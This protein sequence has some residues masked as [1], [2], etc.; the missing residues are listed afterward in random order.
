MHKQQLVVAILAGIAGVVH[1]ASALNLNPN[2]LGQVLIYPYYT[3]NAGQQTLLSVV[4]T[5]NVGKVV[6]VRFLEGYNGR[7][8]LDFNLFLSRNDVW[9]ATL[10]SV[11]DLPG[12]SGGDNSFAG[13]FTT[14]NSCTDP[15]LTGSG[16]FINPATG[17][18]QA[19]QRFVND[20]YTG[21]NADTG[22]TSDA[23]TREGHFELILESDVLIGSVLDNAITHVQPLGMPADCRAGRLESAPGYAPPTLD[24]V[25]GVPTSGVDYAVDGG[26]LGSASIIEVAEGAFYAYN[27]DAL[28]GFSDYDLHGPLNSASPSLVPV[29]TLI[30]CNIGGCPPTLATAN[31]FANGKA[32]AATFVYG[33][34][35]QENRLIDAVSAVFAADNVHNEYV[36]AADGSVGTDWVLT[37][38][39]KRFYVDAQPGGAIAA[40]ITTAT[41]ATAFAPFEELFGQVT[42]GRSCVLVGSGSQVYNREE[43]SAGITTCLVEMESCPPIPAQICLETNVIRFQLGSV[44]GSILPTPNFA[45]L[46]SSGWFSL[47]LATNGSAHSNSGIDGNGHALYPA[48]NGDIFHGLPVTGFAAI[49]YINGSVP[50]SGGGSALANYTAGYHHREKSNC[51]NATGA[52]S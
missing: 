28:D 13:I 10:F 22:P 4:N 32:L 36:T 39:T 23:R 21:A 2:G 31:V 11:G 30:G 1:H 45:P 6:N 5:T 47:D 48:S 8:V 17:A 24:P 19:Y 52:C 35:S 16:T 41:V 37:F 25:T 27:A 40:S 29:D 14:D 51:T 3:V 7:D 18:A 20:N 26:L 34:F 15:A 9:R 38:P 42:D 46:G 50:L 33:Q 43:G 44:L 49:R 12:G